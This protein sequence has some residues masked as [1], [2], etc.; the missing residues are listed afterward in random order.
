MNSKRR[1]ST[2]VLGFLLLLSL[3]GSAAAQ[4]RTVL[5]SPVPGDPIASGTALRNALA[6]IASPSSTNRWLVKI[7]PGT[8]DIGTTSLQMQ[9]WVDIE[10]SGIDATTIRGAVDAIGLNAG[11]VNGAS[12]TELRLLTITANGTGNLNVI[13]L[14]NENAVAMRVYRVKILSVAANGAAWGMRNFASAPLI[15]ECQIDATTSGFVAYGL[16]YAWFVET[17]QRS[18][19]LRSNIAVWGASLNYGV[20]MTQGQTLTVLRDSR[21]DVTGGGTTYG[22]FAI[23][24]F[25]WNGA[26]TLSIRDTEISSAGGANHSAYGVRFE[27]NT[28]IGLEVHSSK[29]WAH[30]APNAS[31]VIQQGLR[32]MTFQ[33]SSV[34]G[35]TTTIESASSVS[36]TSTGLVGGS[37]NVAGWVGCMGVWDENGVFYAN[38]CPQ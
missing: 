5:V 38:S 1:F 11:T 28:S 36:I 21:I 19:I 4:I 24:D 13:G 37:V 15:E 22:L 26:D 14:Y 29:I 34:L 23:A 35:A 8:Y 32:P 10:G 18:S 33:A 20:Y 6:G 17:G 16:V 31:A 30:I 27:G 12:N 9:S 7:E 2:V 25:S 3:N